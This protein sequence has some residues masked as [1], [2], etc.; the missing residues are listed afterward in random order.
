MIMAMRKILLC[1]TIAFANGLFPQIPC[2]DTT[3]VKF[4][5]LFGADPLADRCNDTLRFEEFIVVYS[6]NECTLSGIKPNGRRKWSMR[7]DKKH[8]CEL[9][10]FNTT[11]V[12]RPELCPFDIAVQFG[13]RKYYGLN[14]RN[15]RLK[16]VWIK[17]F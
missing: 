10:Y 17:R 14:A 3:G 9:L 15:G 11:E 2:K 4:D 13:N 6:L 16:W 8:T 7:L 1:T 12:G 5:R